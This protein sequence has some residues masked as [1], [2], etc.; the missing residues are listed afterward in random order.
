[1]AANKFSLSCLRYLFYYSLT[2]LFIYLFIYLSS[3]YLFVKARRLNDDVFS[4]TKVPKYGYVLQ[5]K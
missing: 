2:I 3:I 4:A 5:Q 1:M